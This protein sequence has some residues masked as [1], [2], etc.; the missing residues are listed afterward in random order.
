[1]CQKYDKKQCPFIKGQIKR[2]MAQKYIASKNT[3]NK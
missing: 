1:M 3:L 2:K